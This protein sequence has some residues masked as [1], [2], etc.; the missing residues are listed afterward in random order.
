MNYTEFLKTKEYTY[1]NTGFDIS[2]SELN[3]NLFD[4]QRVIVK[5]ALKKGRCALF[6]DTG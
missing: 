6:L 2:E 4:F 5:W 1:Q 3:S